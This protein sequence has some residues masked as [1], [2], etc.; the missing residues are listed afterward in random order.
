M[1]AGHLHEGAGLHVQPAAKALKAGRPKGAATHQRISE[2]AQLPVQSERA[3]D[4]Q[5][6]A[7]GLALVPAAGLSAARQ[8]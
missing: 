4:A 1:H 7:K 2:P 8:S 3:A 5:V 6:G